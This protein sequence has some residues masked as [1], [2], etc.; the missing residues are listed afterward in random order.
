MECSQSAAKLAARATH[1]GVTNL[2]ALQLGAL[3]NA[4]SQSSIVKLWLG[5]QV[6]DL[7]HPGLLSLAL[8]ET[9]SM[10]PKVLELHC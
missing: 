2:E 3:C 5:Q 10:Q 6:W 1:L 9:C 8:R 7:H 4:T